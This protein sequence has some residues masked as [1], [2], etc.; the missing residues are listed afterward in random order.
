MGIWLNQ[1]KKQTKIK[2]I[3]KILKKQNEIYYY[4]FLLNKKNT[5]FL[6]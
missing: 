4:Y 5:H 1:M 2:N 6:I 3:D